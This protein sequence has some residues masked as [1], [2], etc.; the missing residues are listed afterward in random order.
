MKPK[1]SIKVHHS[2]KELYRIFKDLERYGRTTF[3]YPDYSKQQGIARSIG[4]R[5][6]NLFERD[7]FLPPASTRQ[8]RIN[9][10]QLPIGVKIK[11]KKIYKYYDNKKKIIKEIENIIYSDSEEIKHE[12]REIN[13]KENKRIIECIYNDK[14]SQK[15]DIVKMISI[16]DAFNNEKI[17]LH[18]N[19]KYIDKYNFYKS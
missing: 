1:Y 13:F 9:L 5:G 19:Q 16:T 2:E 10:V 8:H 12:K 14:I 17:E 11:E 4:I 15:K 7:L 18:Y 6:K 3:S